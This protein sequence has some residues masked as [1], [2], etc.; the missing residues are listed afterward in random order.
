MTVY[1]KQ[2]QKSL[3]ISSLFAW[4]QVL[5]HAKAFQGNK[6]IDKRTLNK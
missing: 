3:H 4:T 1:G 5:K 2:W 6:Y